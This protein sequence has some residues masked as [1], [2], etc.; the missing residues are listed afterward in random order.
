MS[1]PST[2]VM[3]VEENAMRERDMEIEKLLRIIDFIV[4][5]LGVDKRAKIR[6]NIERNIIDIDLSDEISGFL[7]TVYTCLRKEENDKP[8][9]IRF[10]EYTA[11]ISGIDVSV[12]SV[13]EKIRANKI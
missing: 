3:E 7:M 2:S 11:Q 6:S 8:G 12:K 5:E 13:V 1:G 4:L 9:H 10:L